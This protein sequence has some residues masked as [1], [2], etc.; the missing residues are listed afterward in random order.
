MVGFV[1]IVAFCS[2][3]YA[4][5]MMIEA[6]LPVLLYQL[7]RLGMAWR[8]TAK[9]MHCLFA[10][11]VVMA[12]SAVVGAAHLHHHLSARGRLIS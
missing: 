12:T 10:I 3:Q 11:G 9:Q 4:G 6:S 1:L 2:Q 7:V 8:N 5:F